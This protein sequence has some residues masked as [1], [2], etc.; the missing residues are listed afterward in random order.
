MNKE[1]EI[2]QK[3]HSVFV[4][5][6]GITDANINTNLTRNDVWNWDSLGHLRLIIELEKTFKITFSADEKLSIFSLEDIPRIV[7]S[8]LAE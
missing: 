8:H 1:L 2:K 4:E 7:L 5:T 6:F 3:V